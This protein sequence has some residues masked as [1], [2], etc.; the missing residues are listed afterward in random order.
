MIPESDKSFDESPT[1]R[2]AASG[3][4]PSAGLLIA[5]LALGLLAG[6]TMGWISFRS[7]WS[8]TAGPTTLF[9]ESLVS[10]LFENAS[11]AV[12]EINVERPTARSGE[13]T[14]SGS[15][16]LVDRAGHIV[17][18]HH[19]LDG[20]GD[21]TVL[22][23]DG[24]VLP[25]T[26]LGTS[27]A[28]D[29]AL[30]SVAPDEVSEVEPLRLA[31][32]DKVRPGQMAIAIGSPFRQANSV[33][34][35]VVSGTGRDQLSVLRRPIP[36]LIQTD[37]ALNPGNSGGPLLN[38]DGEVIGIN[39]SVVIAASVQIG[40]GFAIPSKT[41]VGILTALM[42][43]GE[44]KRPWLGIESRNLN[45]QTFGAIGLP[46]DEGIY[47]VHVCQGSP[48][49]RIGLRADPRPVPTGQADLITG[50]DGNP[51][52]SVS[53]MVGYLNTLQ[54]GDEVTLTILRDEKSQNIDVALA[55]WQACR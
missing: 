41:L 31:D 14:A 44:L 47:I 53:E 32:S 23:F 25:A 39:S 40:V 1:K 42:R 12:V 19:V 15:G 52:A 18:N 9:D 33:S 22:L 28:D 16:F 2:P 46:A 26:K 49:D 20:G 7:P 45:P 13:S 8:A 43:P 48:A 24:R 54:P 38:S 29:L 3:L 10:S 34:V 36:N 37:A 50:V 5:V 17:T 55:E 30:L 6:F 35:G 4:N 21:V 11:R 51:V 27:P